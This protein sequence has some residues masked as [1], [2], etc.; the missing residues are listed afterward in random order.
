MP[1]TSFAVVL[2]TAALFCL[3]GCSHLGTPGKGTASAST[4]PPP[5]APVKVATA[6]RREMP[7]ELAAMGNVEAFS[8]I[9]VKAQIGGTLM[10]VHFREG[11]MVRKGDLLFEIDPRPYQEAI[12]QA[13]ANLARNQ[14]LL[15]LGE[16]NLARA[17]AQEVHY[18][19]QAD[20]YAKLADQGIFSRE[21]ADQMAVELKSR[22]SGVR[23]ESAN[24]ESVKAAIR[25]DEA[26]LSAAKLNLTYCT[27]RS[28]INGR[29]GQVLVKAGNLVKAIDVDLVTI[30]QIQPV[31]VA[32]SV[33]EV[34]LN[35]IRRRLASGSGAPVFAIVPSEKPVT[36]KLDFIDNTVDQSTGTVR[37]KATFANGNLGLWPGQFV[38]VRL[39]LEQRSNVVTVPAAAIQTGQSGTFVYVVGST[40]SVEIRPV[41]TGGRFENLVAVETGLQGEEQVVTEGHLRLARGVKVRVTP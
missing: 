33:P 19:L 13:E 10:E 26:A 12:R 21:Q 17:Q 16:A 15:Q 30:H 40:N 3:A 20:R 1:V 34:N 38:D 4:A 2:V 24:I 23:A 41:T 22:R 35:P 31:Y 28:P 29:T 36:G 27:I 37:L 9:V 18:G 25:A 6:Q 32:F 8:T 11:D 7:V 14:A 5:G 39:R